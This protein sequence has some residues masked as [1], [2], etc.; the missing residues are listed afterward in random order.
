[1][2]SKFA[3]MILWKADKDSEEVLKRNGIVKNSDLQEPCDRF[4]NLS[5]TVGNDEDVADGFE[6]LF[7][8]VEKDRALE[9]YAAM[10]TV[11][12]I[13]SIIL[14]L[15]DIIL[16]NSDVEELVDGFENLYKEVEKEKELELDD[17]GEEFEKEHFKKEEEIDKLD[18][19]N[20]SDDIDSESERNI[21]NR[22]EKYEVADEDD[23]FVTLMVNNLPV[24]A[25]KNITS[26]TTICLY[27]QQNKL[28]QPEYTLTLWNPEED[29]WRLFRA[30]FTLNG[31]HVVG[32]GS[33]PKKA[34]H[35]A[36]RK[37]LHNN[38]MSREISLQAEIFFFLFRH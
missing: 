13:N 34:E 10:P 29:E 25:R 3:E 27:C 38:F 8:S 24:T 36:A 32:S 4:E 11:K 21:P 12:Y 1:M 23:E 22:N 19:K 31:K 7:E 2:K 15:N 18:K 20:V 5:K 37:Y 26:K 28:P 17:G 9:L 33:T 16:K 35:A 14:N 30:R 6:Q